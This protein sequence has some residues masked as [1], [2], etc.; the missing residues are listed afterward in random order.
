[1]G[2]QSGGTA[3]DK[4]KTAPGSY[5]GGYTPGQ[6]GAFAGDANSSVA[7][8][9]IG[10][11]MTAPGPALP[12]TGSLEGWFNWQ[13]G[14]A[15]MRDGTGAVGTGWILAY[16]GGGSLYYRLGGTS[17]NTGLTTASIQHG[18]AHR[19]GAQERHTRARSRRDRRR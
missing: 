17:F 8:D 7:F 10:G 13:G 11:E 4:T 1:L 2:E 3:A 9:G 18:W 12:S 6:P 15:V 14:V 19:R 5:L 16:D